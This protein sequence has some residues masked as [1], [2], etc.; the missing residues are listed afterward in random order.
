MLLTPTTLH[1]CKYSALNLTHSPYKRDQRKRQFHMI[2]TS[3]YISRVQM[4]TVHFSNC[5]IL[6]EISYFEMPTNLRNRNLRSRAAF[7]CIA[8]KICL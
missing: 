6:S 5:K 1:M 8:T 2:R 7:E 3:I 4:N